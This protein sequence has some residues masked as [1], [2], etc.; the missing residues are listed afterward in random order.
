M[1][2]K[3]IYTKLAEKTIDDPDIRDFLAKIIQFE[4]ELPGWY[5]KEYL[6]ILEEFCDGV[7]DN[8]V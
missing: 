6:K 5:E 7:E 4:R 3:T 8:E 2:T 1:A